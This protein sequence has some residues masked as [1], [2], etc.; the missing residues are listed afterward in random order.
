MNIEEIDKTSKS[1]NFDENKITKSSFYVRSMLEYSFDFY[2]VDYHNCYVGG[3]NN[4]DVLYLTFRKPLKNTDQFYRVLNA[5]SID[6]YFISYKESENWY[7]IKMYIPMQYLS[8]Y[9]KFLD[10]KY[11]LLSE[12][13]KDNLL[14]LL[15]KYDKTKLFFNKVKAALYPNKELRKKLE[16]LLNVTLEIDAEIASVPNIEIER[17]N[18]SYF[19][20]EDE[21]SKGNY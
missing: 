18:D 8:D 14:T 2:G 11:S 6:K 13:F 16:D 3:D 9:Y 10:G 4:K 12:D 7:I 15:L 20:Q 19:R 21:D 5:L 1:R 17:Y